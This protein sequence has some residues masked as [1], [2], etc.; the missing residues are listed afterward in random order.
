MGSLDGK[1]QAASAAAGDVP[2]R[3]DNPQP[4]LETELAA[5]RGTLL[6]LDSSTAT[7]T[8]AQDSGRSSLEPQTMDCSDTSRTEP[9]QAHT[10][11][12][13]RRRQGGGAGVTHARKETRY[14]R[15]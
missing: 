5:T 10:K 7:G 11:D 2:K 15:R 12:G 6:G 14:L 8:S 4:Q 1:Q 3:L 9:G 13:R